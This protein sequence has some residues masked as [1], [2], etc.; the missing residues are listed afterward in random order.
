VPNSPIGRPVRWL[1]GIVG[2]GFA[3]VAVAALFSDDPQ[4]GP[5]GLA[6]GVF[7]L[8]FLIPALKAEPS[9]DGLVFSH[10]LTKYQRANAARWS[11]LGVG[12]IGGFLGRLLGADRSN[13]MFV[14]G[15]AWIAGLVLCFFASYYL[16]QLKLLKEKHDAA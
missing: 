3:I 5:I 1:A 4:A 15:I 6:C 12:F 8:L 16:E 7:G 10:V 2:G 13:W 11:C 9:V 14:F